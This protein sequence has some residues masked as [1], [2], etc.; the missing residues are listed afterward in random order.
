MPEACERV[1]GEAR[2]AISRT[3]Q[4]STVFGELKSSTSV[5]AAKGLSAAVAATYELFHPVKNLAA[6]KRR[7]LAHRVI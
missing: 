1:L 6:Q 5:T 3:N 4:R 7:R 2:R